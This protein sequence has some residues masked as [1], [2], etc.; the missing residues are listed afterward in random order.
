MPLV[1]TSLGTKKESV[2]VDAFMQNCKDESS[3]RRLLATR[4]RVL[5]LLKLSMRRCY[6]SGFNNPGILFGATTYLLL[7]DSMAVMSIEERVSG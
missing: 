2:N 7:T 3:H 6:T 1:E 4:R 5:A